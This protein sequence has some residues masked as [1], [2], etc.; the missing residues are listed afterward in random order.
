[1][2]LRSQQALIVGLAGALAVW[3]GE[4]AVGAGFARH[5]LIDMALTGFALGATMNTWRAAMA[6]GRERLAWSW[7]FF[8]ALAWTAGQLFWDAFD[9]AGIATAK[10]NAADIGRLVAGACWAIGCAAFLVGHRQRLAVYALVLD[11]GAAVLT[12]VAGVALYVSEVFSSEMI[13]DPAATTAGLAYPVLYVAATGAALSMFWGLPP[14][15]TRRAH[16]TLLV[17]IVLNTVGFVLWLPDY[18]HESLAPGSILDVCWMVGTLAI[19][20]AGRQWYEDPGGRE[21]PLV[22][23]TAVQFSRM[24][25]PGAVAFAAATILIASQL[26]KQ[27]ATDPII[28]VAIAL[29]IVLLAIRAGLALYSNWR[30]G[31]R[32]RRRAAQF[33]ALYDVGLATAGLISLGDLAKLAV[34]NATRITQTDGAMIALEDGEGRFVIRA[35]N[36]SKMPELRDATGDPLV[37]IAL[38]C[39][40]TREAAIAT[41]Y[42]TH[43]DANPK[44]HG[45]IKSALALP[46]IAHG[47][48]VGTMT[49]Y[50]GRPRHWGSE[51]LRIFRLYAAQAAIAIANAR[52][53]SES[54]RLA[55]DDP[56]TGLTNRRV[57]VERL[58]AEAA[59][60]RRHGDAFCVIL[61]DVDGLKAVNDT[62]GHLVGDS[63]LRSVATTLRATARTEDVVARFGGDEFVLLLPRTALDAARALV[64]RLARELP[65]QTYMWAGLPHSLPRVS[66]GIAAFPEDGLLADQLI[67]KADERMYQDK[68]RASGRLR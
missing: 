15:Q 20:I 44:L 49:L 18:I 24:A 48:L 13:N 19:G 61:C 57:L 25:L 34:D 67:A 51:T 64:T 17:G 62:A 47:E 5:V 59:E 29:T 8:G 63:V 16:F 35:I 4:I 60:A 68:A 46:L 7:I 39:V 52:L 41:D 32:E 14:Q 22:P 6:G 58:E 23:A 45:V 33:S 54:R 11:A 42:H 2:L 66:Y 50:S 27:T 12:M 36:K 65:E 10:P 56:L 38:E 21:Q 37:G 43:A 26:D 31:I 3:I 1:S 55:S 53:L 30:L 28:A 40:R 9:I